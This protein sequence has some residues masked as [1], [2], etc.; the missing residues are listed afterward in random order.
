MSSR[1]M[2]ALSYFKNH[3]FVIT[4]L[5]IFLFTNIIFN[6]LSFLAGEPSQSTVSLAEYSYMFGDSPKTESGEWAWLEG[7][8][9]DWKKSNFRQ[10]IEK[11][12]PFI[13]KKIILPENTGTQ[14]ALLIRVIHQFFEVY[15]NAKQIYHF[16]DLNSSK[17]SK[18]DGTPWHIINL[19]GGEPVFFRIYSNSHL[20]GLDGIPR[21]DTGNKH[22]KNIFIS[23]VLRQIIATVL[24]FTGVVGV[25]FVFSSKEF[26][27]LWLS[28]FSIAIGINTF[29]W[30]DSVQFFVPF[31]VV[32]EYLKVLSLDL[33]LIFLCI[34]INAILY[35]GKH[36][37]LSQVIIILIIYSVISSLLSLL[38]VN[39]V[40]NPIILFVLPCILTILFLIF[41]TYQS[42]FSKQTVLDTNRKDA[43]ILFASLTCLLIYV[44]KD[45]LARNNMIDWAQHSIYFGAVMI[46]FS[47]LFVIV[48]HH[49]SRVRGLKSSK[50]SRDHLILNTVHEIKI[51]LNGIMGTS[52]KLLDKNPNLSKAAKGNIETII[53]NVRKLFGLVNDTVDSIKL[54]NKQVILNKKAV[55][56]R[57]AVEIV[58]N[59]Y[60]F[61]TGLKNLILSNKVPETLPAA[62]GDYFRLVQILHNLISN[63]IKF[64][65]EG[66]IMAT[67][68]QK[69]DHI[70]ICIED[71]G[72]GIEA[73]K[74][75]HIFNLSEHQEFHSSSNS[76]AGV[77]LYIAKGLVELHGGKIWVESIP[78]KGSKFFFT[79]PFTTHKAE[80]FDDNLVLN[81]LY[82][83]KTQKMNLTS[84]I[85]NPNIL[86]VD[87]DKQNIAQLIKQLAGSYNV[88]QATTG[89]ESLTLIEKNKPDLILLEMALPDISGID[90]CK[91][92]RK[93]YSKTE[94]PIVFQTIK[95]S[96]FLMNEAFSAGGN[97]YIT[98]PF[99][100]VEVIARIENHLNL[101]EEQEKIPEVV[102]Q[103]IK[104]LDD[105][106]YIKSARNYCDLFGYDNKYRLRSLRITL[107]D[108][109]KY[110]H[111]FIRINKSCIVNLSHIKSV[112][113]RGKNYFI[114]FNEPFK[115]KVEFK[116][117]KIYLDA[118]KN[119]IQVIE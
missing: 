60:S 50:I 87:S 66:L 107:N 40:V 52:Q 36:K 1:K 24:L 91:T 75:Q 45:T 59:F 38:G 65:D 118:I 119:Q 78:E 2:T 115:E 116:I 61:T 30:A 33:S 44:L 79:I 7:D 102:Y 100:K 92:I 6:I 90:V 5:S 73:D 111:T 43:L 37:G 94:M 19:N 29:C 8:Q 54:K 101:N 34:F 57:H 93:K 35:K 3:R 63:A 96:Y 56:V 80:E 9:V 22:L 104:L 77:G 84:S 11:K 88:M 99:T 72:V 18:Y 98:K 69:F 68:E 26:Q 55:D 31:S 51:P 97:D 83:E 46:V 86:V 74:L 103:I 28:L 15:Q 17:G 10:K 64:T 108:I 13:W 82:T 16:G 113:H 25:M 67:A 12:K 27:I 41:T 76:L 39:S 32:I 105:V 62:H 47:S 85:D 110:L 23:D 48:S 4:L 14:K 114:D 49:L 20:I 81:N 106:A 42:V 109:C 95:D 58:L 71:T 53:T 117:S 70:E 21:L 89:A 112:N